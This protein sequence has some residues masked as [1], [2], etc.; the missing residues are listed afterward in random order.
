MKFDFGFLSS[1]TISEALSR[2]K[3]NFDLFRLLAALA[4]IYGH[5]YSIV[6]EIG[7]Q[8]VLHLLTGNYWSQL[9]AVNFFFFLSGLLVTNS[10]FEGKSVPK[11]LVT[12]F[13]RIWPGLA[14]VVIVSA[15]VIGPLVTGLN[16]GSYFGNSNVLFYIKHQLLMETWNMR[17]LG[18]FDLPGVY[19]NNYYKNDVNVSLWTLV[20][21]VFAY[22]FLAA[23]FLCGLMKQRL[24]SVIMIIIMIDSLLPTRII[25]PFLQ[26]NEDYK[27]LPFCF[28]AGSFLALNKQKIQIS[29]GV[30]IGF[31]ALCL[32]MHGTAFEQAFFYFTIF[33][34]TIFLST[35]TIILKLGL[36]LD[37]SYG[38]YLW[39]WPVQQILVHLFPSLSRTENL[40]LS[41]LLS[42]CMGI[43]SWVFVERSAIE[44]GKSVARRLSTLTQ[45][46]D[47][48]VVDNTVVLKDVKETS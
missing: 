27:Y 8:D 35:R 31:L 42:V 17:G 20:A 45:T 16:F 22:L 7:K 12:R 37:V 3:N 18:Y 11:F 47:T 2:G 24:A 4:V 26:G 19:E 44:F 1:I 39:G 48:R 36:P 41:M 32:L 28:A 15:L 43:I 46:I 29:I 33:S 40:L 38:V 5:S 21:E 13:F 23:T 34:S 6:P 25:F 10:L 30:P 14:L 9:V